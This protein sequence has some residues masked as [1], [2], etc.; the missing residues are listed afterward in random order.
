MENKIIGYSERG[1][2]N[3]ILYTIGND[4]KKVA[5]FLTTIT[6]KKVV[7]SDNYKIYIEHS[8]SGFGSPDTVIIHN[9]VVYF[10]EFKVC[11]GVKTWSLKKQCEDYKSKKYDAS[12]VFYQLY[13]KKLLFDAEVEGE[14]VV[15]DEKANGKG[16]D[17]ERK[18]GSNE[19][20]KSLFDE[21]KND[22][23]SGVEYIGIVPKVEKDFGCGE[24]GFLF[25]EWSKLLENYGDCKMV[26][27]TMKHNNKN[28]QI[29][30]P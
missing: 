14:F 8:L 20:V 2:M 28:N 27:D 1:I 18:I 29:Y 7:A 24:E 12:N 16:K 5:E 25:C 22:K 4:K 13:L 11:A 23:C 19:C 9:N 17:M 3:A 10:I 15:K 30:Y 6:G 21:I 26:T